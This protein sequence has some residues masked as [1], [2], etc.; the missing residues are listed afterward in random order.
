MR[1]T[2]FFGLQQPIFLGYP[3]VR[4]VTLD[5]AWSLARDALGGPALAAFARLPYLAALC[6][7]FAQG[8]AAE[9]AAVEEL[10]P[11]WSVL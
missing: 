10:P 5:C 3:H 9:V 4:F 11:R 8:S 2:Q 6:S 7:Q 1:I